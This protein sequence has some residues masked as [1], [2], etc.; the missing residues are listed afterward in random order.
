ML[1]WLL[2]L[3]CRQLMQENQHVM[4]YR[5]LQLRWSR[6]SHTVLL[7]LLAPALY[8]GQVRMEFIARAGGERVA[9]AEVCFFKAGLGPGPIDKFAGEENLRCLPADQVIEMPDGR[10]V[11]VVRHQGKKLLSTNPAI[12]NVHSAGSPDDLFHQSM[13]DMVKAGVLDLSRVNGALRPDDHL[14]LYIS[15][16]G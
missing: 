15:N 9:G 7:L 5:W 4:S 3:P 16:Q 2:Y 1:R 11:F 12:V 14:A 13:E 8:A 6:G 10:W